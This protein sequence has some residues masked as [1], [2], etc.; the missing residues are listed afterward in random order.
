MFWKSEN[1]ELD[2]CI[3]Q[4]GCLKRL[5]NNAFVLDTSAL[6]TI[7]DD[8]AEANGLQKSGNVADFVNYWH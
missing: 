7:L 5:W 4:R 6:H 3:I 8:R 2:M 1:I